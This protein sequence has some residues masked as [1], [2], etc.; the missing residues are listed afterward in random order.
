MSDDKE[1]GYCSDCLYENCGFPMYCS[2]ECHES[3]TGSQFQDEQ[4]VTIIKLRKD[5]RIL[6]NAALIVL[7]EDNHM[8][9]CAVYT[10][11]NGNGPCDCEMMGLREALEQ[12]K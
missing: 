7:G 2:C 9:D 11:G 12:I 4:I 1:R 6:S 5:L 8:S 3:A 10:H